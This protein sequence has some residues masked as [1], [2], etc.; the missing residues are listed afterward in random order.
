MD[1]GPDPESVCGGG[2]GQALK[3]GGVVGPQGGLGAEPQ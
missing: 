1:P 2:G 3:P